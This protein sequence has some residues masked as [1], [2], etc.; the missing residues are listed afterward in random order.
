MQEHS[1]TT[2]YCCQLFSGHFFIVHS[3]C[4]VTVWIT[5][6]KTA[7]LELVACKMTCI[8]K[9]K[10]AL[11]KQK[12]TR[13]SSYSNLWGWKFGSVAE[14]FILTQFCRIWSPQRCKFPRP[15]PDC[16]F[17]RVLP[18]PQAIR[19]RCSTSLTPIQYQLINCCRQ[20]M[21]RWLRH[22]APTRAPYVLQRFVV[23]FCLFSTSTF[24]T[25]HAHNHEVTVETSACVYT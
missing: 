16:P 5:I 12:C 17:H 20:F 14:L 18:S 13:Y 22:S 10:R 25:I 23:H 4:F 24:S 8:R 1:C 3:N 11:Y 9:P 15:A 6:E 19:S 7:L 2:V 21:E